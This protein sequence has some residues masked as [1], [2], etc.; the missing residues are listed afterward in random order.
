MAPHALTPHR[1]CRYP[2]GCHRSGTQA[3]RPSTT[4]TTGDKAMAFTKGHGRYGYA[5]ADTLAQ[6]VLG[7]KG[8]RTAKAVILRDDS[9][10]LARVRCSTCGRFLSEYAPGNDFDP[11]SPTIQDEYHGNRIQYSPKT[12]HI[13]PMHYTCAWSGLLS[14]LAT[15][16]PAEA[17]ARARFSA[18]QGWQLIPA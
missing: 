18:T 13:K 7:F 16:D 2:R 4:T 17:A 14:D 15:G 6:L 5:K 12:K 9:P 3:L 1:E 11:E 10:D 8:C